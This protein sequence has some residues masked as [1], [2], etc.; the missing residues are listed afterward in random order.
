MSYK[1]KLGT[2]KKYVESTAQPTVTGWAEYDVVFK[3]GTDIVNPTITLSIDYNTVK[4]YNYAY[5][6][7]RYYWIVSKTLLRTGLCE[8]D[9]KTDVLATYKSDIG[10]SSLY[11]LRS[12]ASYNGAI[13][14]NLYPTTADRTQYLV[15]S[16]YPN[17]SYSTGVYVVNVMGSL[18][19]GA[20]TLYQM[21]PENF[22]K[23]VKELYDNVDGF[24]LSDVVN[25]VV[26]KFGGNPEKLL[27][28]AMWFP[29]AFS[30][31]TSTQ[32]VRIGSWVS[33][34]VTAKV[35]NDPSETLTNINMSID[36]HPQAASR[37]KYLNLSPY[38]NYELALP[39]AGIIRLDSTKLIGCSSIDIVR[40][41]D[42]FTGRLRY[43][44]VANPDNLTEDGQILAQLTTQWGVPINLSGQNIGS[45]LIT[46]TIQ[47][48]GLVG[49]FAATGGAAAIIGASTAAIGTTIDAISGGSSSSGV[50]GALV[51]LNVPCYINEIF[52]TVV[53]EDNTHNGRPYCQVTTPA[54]LTGFM[55]AQRGDVDIN[56]TLPE[57]E[58]IKAFLESG[59]YYE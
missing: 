4:A 24:Q 17:Y 16:A 34:T 37:G 21:T 7:D 10:A 31:T 33:S 18:S 51:L 39:G 52:Y 9:L 44:V 1:I 28:G 58:E 32:Y 42:A 6:L 5:M 19:G 46:G 12:S 57:E 3:N 30:S 23:L 48:A 36:K 43:Q 49:A 14:D 11:I 25:Q 8:I 27:M 56:G 13:R 29:T 47:T 2:F 54:T 53:N 50:G 38:S 59:F 55:I 15:A 45:D 35:I 20:S 22:R 26:K 41:V 40:D